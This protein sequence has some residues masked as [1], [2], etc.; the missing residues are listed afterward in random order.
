MCL[1]FGFDQLSRNNF[2]GKLVHV[3]KTSQIPSRCS[4]GGTP[5]P[6]CRIVV[7]YT[8]SQTSS[9]TFAEKGAKGVSSGYPFWRVLALLPGHKKRVGTTTT[10]HYHNDNNNN[11]NDDDD[12]DDDNN[13]NIMNNNI[14]NKNSSSNSSSNNNN[15]N[16]KKKKKKKKAEK[17]L[18]QRFATGLWRKHGIDFRL[19]K[20]SKWRIAN[21][22]QW[23][24][25]SPMA[26]LLDFP[27]Q[28]LQS[29]GR[30]NKVTDSK[31]RGLGHQ[32]MENK[33]AEFWRKQAQQ[34]EYG[35]NSLVPECITGFAKRIERPKYYITLR[36]V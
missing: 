36:S 5:E 20:P 2:K 33:P 30:Q 7:F 32:A 1:S 24:E 25:S 10:S 3:A 31:P 19:L 23:L 16:N 18:R 6:H 27:S 17:K 14:I 26:N 13:N 4:S 28:N 15:N 34:T 9:L 12:D 22:P 21:L 8:W 35:R 11:N 29:D